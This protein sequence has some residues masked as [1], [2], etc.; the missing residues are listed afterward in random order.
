MVV[1]TFVAHAA[2][3]DNSPVLG[4]DLQG[5]ISVVLAPVGEVKQPGIARQG[6]RHHPQPGR[7][8][9]ASPSP[10][11]AARATTSIIDLP[12]VRDRD[13]ARRLVGQTAE[14][15]FR[16]VLAVLPPRGAEPTHHDDDHADDLDHVAA[17]AATADARHRPRPP[18]TPEVATDDAGAERQGRAPTVVPP[19]AR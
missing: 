13:K 11:S 6:R 8:A 2:L 18:R 16:P 17:G 9:S 19:G 12:G 15:R 3:R 4:L 1:G 10:R 7:L 14:L 5:G